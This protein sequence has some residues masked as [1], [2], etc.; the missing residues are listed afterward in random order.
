MHFEHKKGLWVQSGL[1][2]TKI[3]GD[4]CVAHL[5]SGNSGLGEGFFTNSYSW[6]IA[7]T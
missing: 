6:C 3:T 2:Q 1:M 7:G 5:I 4:L